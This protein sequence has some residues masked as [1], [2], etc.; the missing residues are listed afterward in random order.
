MT[1]SIQQELTPADIN[2]PYAGIKL[3]ILLARRVC[4]R[5]TT[6]SAI[7]STLQGV[8][9]DSIA[10][11]VWNELWPPF[12]MIIAA[13]EEEVQS[14]YISVRFIINS[15]GSAWLSPRTSHDSR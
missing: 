8:S 7:P 9:E 15:I 2:H 12:L 10:K 11:M 5:R 14:G 3:W 1:A 4:G 13:F 6:T